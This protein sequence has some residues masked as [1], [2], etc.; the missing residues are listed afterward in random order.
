MITG[1]LGNLVMEGRDRTVER[2]VTA[3]VPTTR[4]GEEGKWRPKFER[5]VGWG[6]TKFNT[7]RAKTILFQD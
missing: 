4:L 7:P 1:K 2:G 5:E 6:A 3:T